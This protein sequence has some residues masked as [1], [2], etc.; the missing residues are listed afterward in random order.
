MGI[1][2]PGRR[3]AAMNVE[4]GLSFLAIADNAPLAWT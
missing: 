3:A 1:V 4:W 2:F